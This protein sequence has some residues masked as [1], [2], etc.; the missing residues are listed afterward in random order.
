MR[1][2]LDSEGVDALWAKMKTYVA[3]HSSGSSESSGAVVGAIQMYGG[4]TAPKG[5]L[6]CDGSAVSRTTYAKLFEVLG[7]AYGAGD[8][9]T[10]FNVPNFS[11]RFPIGHCNTTPITNTSSCGYQGGSSAYPRSGDTVGWFGLGEAGGEDSHVLT[12]AEMPS[13]NHSASTG[14]AGSHTHAPGGSAV[15]FHATTATSADSFS[16]GSIS[17]SGYKV[18]RVASKYSNLSRPETGS[19]GGHTHS[20]SVSNAGSSTTHNN[21][22][23][24]LGVNYIIFAG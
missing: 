7:T 6:L 11:G 18:P 20:V 8:G 2:Y 24:F 22:P 19:A 10:T 1:S 3:N 5:W 16:G 4:A 9:S 17:G 15:R 12:T 21:M 13:H 14:S 23:P